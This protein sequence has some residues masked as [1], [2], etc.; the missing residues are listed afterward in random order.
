M[1]TEHSPEAL[2][3]PTALFLWP[4]QSQSSLGAL[5]FFQLPQ[6]WSGQITQASSCLGYHFPVR[7]SCVPN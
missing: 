7:T 6:V 1:G 5:Y 2:S 4:E 3:P